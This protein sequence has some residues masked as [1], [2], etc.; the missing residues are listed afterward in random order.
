MFI[1]LFV[2]I[3]TL[4]KTETYQLEETITVS[5]ILNSESSST[6]PY[7]LC[8][9]LHVGKLVFVGNR[10]LS[11]TG[12]SETVLS[13]PHSPILEENAEPTAD[14]IFLLLNSTLALNHLSIEEIEAGG[15]I[16]ELES[17]VFKA[18]AVSITI[19]TML[20]F[21]SIIDSS[22]S[23]SFVELN[24]ISVTS[25]KERIP[26][27]CELAPEFETEPLITVSNV[28]INSL[29][30]HTTH[31]VVV[32]S[33][34]APSFH[35]ALIGSTFTNMSL[36]HPETFHRLPHTASQTIL[37]TVTF[38]VPTPLYNE[39]SADLNRGGTFNAQNV[40][41]THGHSDSLTD[42]PTST[43][44]A[45]ALYSDYTNLTFR[46]SDRAYGEN[47]DLSIRFT[48]CL[49]DRMSG[50]Y[51]NGVCV[52]ILGHHGSIRFDG[53]KFDSC[54]NSASEVSGGCVHIVNNQTYTS[55]HSFIWCDFLQCECTGYSSVYG[56]CIA[57]F[58]ASSGL[59]DNC[60][61]EQCQVTHATSGGGTISVSYPQSTFK[62]AN[63]RFR[64]G[65]G[66]HVGGIYF[67]QVIDYPVE[68]ASLLF[69]GCEMT[70]A[71]GY[72]NDIF[73]LKCTRP[74]QI[75]DKVSYCLT[76]DPS[77]MFVINTVGME[78]INCDSF[79]E[80][81]QVVD[82]ERGT[83]GILCWSK[84]NGCKTIE[85]AV[86]EYSESKALQLSVIYTK[87]VM[88]E[89]EIKFKRS[90]SVEGDDYSG[91]R[92]LIRP[93]KDRLITID[94]GNVSIAS[95]DFEVVG[96]AVLVNLKENTEL[97]L[98][99]CRV[100]S[101]TATSTSKAGALM[102]VKEGGKLTLNDIKFLQI[103]FSNVVPDESVPAK[104]SLIS[105]V[106]PKLIKLSNVQMSNIET[107][108]DGAALNGTLTSSSTLVLAKTEFSNVRSTGGDGG[109]MNLALDSKVSS[110]PFRIG[111]TYSRCSCPSGKKGDWIYIE[112]HGLEKLVRKGDWDGF[113]VYSSTNDNYFM[114][115]DLSLSGD[116]FLSFTKTVS[117]SKG[118][119]IVGI[120]IGAVIGTLVLVGLLIICCCC[121][122]LCA[123]CCAAGSRGGYYR[124]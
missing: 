14:A 69:F 110:S 90:V 32:S 77:P 111:A 20:P 42:H 16:A 10:I 84:T 28:H 51:A 49:F 86:E 95:F 98:S 38:Q 59:I 3:T 41:F 45:N 54:N 116:Q 44:Y 83:D 100:G 87:E 7:T 30:L 106:L 5:D 8:E 9:G 11:L 103:T 50:S 89:K 61:F 36:T 102:R 56:V 114:G 96:E 75:R 26:A 27:F 108:S 35:T 92:I 43:Q 93:L 21:M 23:K 58:W 105:F 53:C 34:A 124:Q 57:I 46:S 73:A 40:S 121:C 63:T 71:G 47:Y 107:P 1:R 29:V 24:G 33:S 64:D 74:G 112:G 115:R 79:M 52:C 104:G 76:R 2:F 81:L 15:R 39:I 70:K 25:E 85:Y 80:K 4:V 13:L 118:S 55:T 88:E 82:H 122:P 12:H 17:S 22:I 60:L 31:S 72:A 120:I 113:P 109:V 67:D 48:N 97:V 91:Q 37:S 94:S 68:M 123:C 99:S 101:S 119:V 66:P 62:I 65:A 6:T 78:M 18:N 19:R 117:P